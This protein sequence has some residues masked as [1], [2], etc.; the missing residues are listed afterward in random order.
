MTP[1]REPDIWLTAADIQTPEFRRCN[2]PGTGGRDGRFRGITRGDVA[3]R[4]DAV[5]CLR[6]VDA[7][8][9]LVKVEDY[10]CAVSRMAEPV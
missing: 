10:R 7:A 5:V 9:A 8:S 4:V 2:A 3:V 6:V 1:D